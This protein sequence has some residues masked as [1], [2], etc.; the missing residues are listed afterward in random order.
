LLHTGNRIIFFITLIALCSDTG[1]KQS[2][3]VPVRIVP[4]QVEVLEK[5]F[6]S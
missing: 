3:T 1:T 4:L 5:C 2:C 6:I